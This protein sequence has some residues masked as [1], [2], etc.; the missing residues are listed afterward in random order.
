MGDQL[1]KNFLADS[2]KPIETQ[3]R[4][5]QGHM[6]A[7]YCTAVLVAYNRLDATSS[8]VDLYLSNPYEG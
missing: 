4:V 3:T 5:L 8:N 2:T 6:S 7:Y 1:C